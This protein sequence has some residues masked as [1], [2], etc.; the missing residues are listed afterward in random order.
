M[1][2][3]KLQES[4]DKNGNVRYHLTLS[5]ELVNQ[6]DWSKG[7][8]ISQDLVIGG[9]GAGQIKLDKVEEE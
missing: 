5:K 3:Y 7:D 2:S 9:S 1:K 8:Q 6:L 4:K